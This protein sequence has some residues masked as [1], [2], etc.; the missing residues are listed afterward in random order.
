MRENDG[1]VIPNFICQ[2]LA[3][4]PITVYGNGCQTRSFCYISDLVDGIYRLIMADVHNPINIG[5]PNEMTLLK[6]AKIIIKLTGS[7]SRI[8]HKPLPC[9]DPKVRCPD[10]RKAHKILNWKP[11]IDIE[12]GLA[13]TIVYFNLET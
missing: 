6:L 4:K 2:A 10:I 5:N 11:Y 7:K 9:D 13:K 1:R 3:G 8:V 12:K